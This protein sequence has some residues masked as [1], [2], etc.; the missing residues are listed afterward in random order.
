MQI[1]GGGGGVAVCRLNLSSLFTTQQTI[2]YMC[3]VMRQSYNL[4][5]AVAAFIVEDTFQCLQHFQAFS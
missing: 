2:L 4:R 5:A 1:M 3:L